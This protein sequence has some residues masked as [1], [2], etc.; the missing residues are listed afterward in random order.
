MIGKMRFT[1][2]WKCVFA[3]PIQFL[4]SVRIL[5]GLKERGKHIAGKKSDYDFRLNHQKKN[6]GFLVFIN[7]LLYYLGKSIKT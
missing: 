6:I 5:L 2:T 7:P 4:L 3:D 1:E